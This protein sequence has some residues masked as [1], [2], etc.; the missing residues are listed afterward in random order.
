MI[1]YAKSCMHYELAGDEETLKI[2]CRKLL[3]KVWR[4]AYFKSLPE[5]RLERDQMK[6]SLF[7]QQI[8]Y[9]SFLAVH[10]E[11][12]KICLDTGHANFFDLSAGDAVRLL[13]KEYL[14]TLHIH[15]NDGNGDRHW[16][17]FRGLI[18]WE[19]F[20]NA[21]HEI[22]YEG[23]VSL[24]SNLPKLPGELREYE[25]IALCRKARYIAVLAAGKTTL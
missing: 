18:D 4:T 2:L 22:K 12:F 16:E 20:C 24:E 8:P 21:L 15:D 13:G 1:F 23:V 25:E 10:S 14:Y 6:E 3:R 7:M 11:Y 5:S 17:P 19:D 9:V